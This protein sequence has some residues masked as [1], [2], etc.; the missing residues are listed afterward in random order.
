MNCEM[1]DWEVIKLDL[2]AE[3]KIELWSLMYQDLRLFAARKLEDQF[4][5]SHDDA[6]IIVM[7][8]NQS[9][10]CNQC[11]FDGLKHAYINCPQC[12]SFNYNIDWEPPFNMEFCTHLEYKLDFDALEDDRLKGFWCD[13]VSFLPEDITS[14]FPDKLEHN[15]LIQTKA[16]IGHDGQGIYKMFIHFGELSIRNYLENKELIS[17]IPEALCKEWINIDP[18]KQVIEVCLL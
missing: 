9:G 14:L 10:Q 6:E 4:G 5:V 3:L 12:K 7:H 8:L 15:R 17:C 1:C 11:N 13:G 18:E 16:W 2:S